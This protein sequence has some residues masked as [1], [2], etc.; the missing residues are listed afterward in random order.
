MA[1]I[2]KV[3]ARVPPLIAQLVSRPLAPNMG[4]NYAR[5]CA[6]FVTARALLAGTLGL[7]DFD[8]SV[9]SDRTSL[10]LA[11]RI[12]IVTDTNA[13]TPITVEIGLK[14]GSSYTV[15]LTDVFGSPA[16]PLSKQE[17][18]DK[19]FSNWTAGAVPLPRE[20]ADRLIERIATLEKVT[21]IRELA[22]LLVR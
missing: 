20:N 7:A 5:L 9:L 16:N 14:T 3:V 10:D 21:E 4:V 6:R 22:D 18:L 15:T 1:D 8:A 13:L 19:F 11:A 2:D 12:D 17:H